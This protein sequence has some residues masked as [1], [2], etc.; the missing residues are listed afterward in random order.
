[1]KTIQVKE[2]RTKAV[3]LH[4]E[5]CPKCGS[6][7]NVAVYDDGSKWCFGCGY[8]CPPERTLRDAY[9]TWERSCVDYAG[10]NFTRTIPAKPRQWLLSYGITPD[11]ISYYG[12]MWDP[13]KNLLV[14]PIYD[15]G[16]MIGFNGRVFPAG[17]LN[18]DLE[19]RRDFVPKYIHSGSKDTLPI[20]TLDSDSDTAIFVEGP[21]DAIKVAREYQ[22]IPLYGSHIDTKTILLASER[23]LEVGIW[24]DRDKAKKSFLELQKATMT[25]GRIKVFEVR[26]EM[27]PK[28]YSG[29]QIRKL[30]EQAKGAA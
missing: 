20:L 4:H 28:V 5:P 24:L 14:F 3:F 21:L 2:S 23:F 22:A 9:N 15:D 16:K 1:M 7:D 27:D 12:V 8:Y 19:R 10:Y 29:D 26:S 17:D 30:V 11:E 25:I 18:H 13:G 6:R